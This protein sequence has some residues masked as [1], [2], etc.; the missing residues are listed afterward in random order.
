MGILREMIKDVNI[1]IWRDWS[2]WKAGGIFDY[3]KQ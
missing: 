3:I 2:G 1:I